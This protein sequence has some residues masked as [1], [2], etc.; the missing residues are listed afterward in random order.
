MSKHMPT[1]DGVQRAFRED[2]C[3]RCARRP[4]YSEGLGPEVVR[5]CELSCPVFV[6]LAALYFFAAMGD[7][8]LESRRMA[9][10]HRVA[11]YCNQDGKVARAEPRWL[12]ATRRSPL[13]RYR[14]QVIDILL[15]MVTET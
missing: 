5:P 14:R 12:T 13:R 8:M 7:P 10:E 3:V 4:R 11:G 1:L 15:R 9:L 2:I 6:H